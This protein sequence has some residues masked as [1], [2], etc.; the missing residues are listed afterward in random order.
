M[1]QYTETHAAHGG[2]FFSAIEAMVARVFQDLRT[3]RE[4]NRTYEEL[5]ALSDR[6]LDDLGLVRA[7]IGRIARESVRVY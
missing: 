7:D 5:S 4:I 3:K 1:A 2:S 6:E